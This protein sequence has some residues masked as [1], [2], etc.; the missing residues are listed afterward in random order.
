MYRA[1]QHRRRGQPA[2]CSRPPR[3]CIAGLRL[4]RR[5]T[6]QRGGHR[7][8]GMGR[9]QGRSAAKRRAAAQGACHLQRVAAEAPHAAGSRRT[10]RLGVGG[11]SSA[12]SSSSSGASGCMDA[13]R[14]RLMYRGALVCI[15][16]ARLS[17]EAAGAQ[18]AARR[19]R[20]ASRQGGLC[21]VQAGG[22]RQP[23]GRVRCTTAACLR[24]VRPG[25]GTGHRA[26]PAR[27]AH[28]L[29]SQLQAVGRR[30]PRAGAGFRRGR[31]L[32]LQWRAAPPGP[33]AARRRC[34]PRRVMSTRSTEAP[35]AARLRAHSVMVPGR[36][37]SG[38]AGMGRGWRR[39]AEIGAGD[40]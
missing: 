1:E 21:G 11:T 31:G 19:G 24:G 22:W 16:S 8:S 18:R 3:V 28:T 10:W 33:A 37:N 6:L 39:A 29:W 36:R 34:P 12:Q 5:R 4:A 17:A 7:A 23:A 32:L 30:G 9:P 25:C 13:A 15:A 27:Y 2:G 40:S 35:A 38:P 14:R 20:P 26:G